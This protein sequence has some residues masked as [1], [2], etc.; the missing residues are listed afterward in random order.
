MHQVSII[1]ALAVKRS[2]C[3]PK[4]PHGP[5]SSPQA[6]WH[7][8]LAGRAAGLYHCQQE[9]LHGVSKR[10]T[11][12]RQSPRARSAWW[13]ALLLAILLIGAMLVQRTV[14][15]WEG[16]SATAPVAADLARVVE[17][18]DGDTIRVEVAGKLYTVRYIGIDTPETRHPEKGIEPFGPEA[19]QKN[20][21]LVEGKLVRLEKDV[22]ETDRYGRLLR[23]VWLGDTL[24]NEELVKLGFA[25]VSTFP[26]DV[27]YAER[28]LAAEQEARSA[29]RGL[30]GLA[31]PTA[32][33]REAATLCPG[34]CLT[35]PPGCQIKGNIARDGR[36]LYH[37]PGS[38]AYALTKV[39]PEKGERWFCTAAEAEA[40]GWS[41]AP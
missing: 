35:P 19:A 4:P 7:L 34:G 27:K 15:T 25:R 9:V 14:G 23:Y 18:I 32:R 12:R 29:G 37:L 20:K 41:P 6:P 10:S 17:V 3:A 31:E 40:A 39:D 30:W 24:V 11:A 1:R 28:F 5:T 33:T 38:S 21:E 13:G 2:L 8:R 36:K 26:P 16:T 22:S